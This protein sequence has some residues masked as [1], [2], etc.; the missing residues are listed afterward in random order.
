MTSLTI[1]TSQAVTV[2]QTSY[3]NNYYYPR[4]IYNGNTETVTIKLNG[5]VLN[6]STIT[7]DRD[8]V[9]RGVTLSPNGG[10][11]PTDV[12]TFTFEDRYRTG[13]DWSSQDRKAPWTAT[14]TVEEL[15]NGT[16][17]DFEHNL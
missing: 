1:S 12:L 8:N 9:T 6:N 10:F 16:T 5:N 4:S 15:L 17:L 14:C 2:Q 7:I 11:S 13:R 3:N